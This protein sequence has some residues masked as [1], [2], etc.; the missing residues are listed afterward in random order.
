MARKKSAKRRAKPDTRP[1][2]LWTLAIVLAV[3]VL[4]LGVSAFDW[5]PVH[6]DEG[7]YWAYGQELAAGHF[8]KPPLVG[9]IIFLTTELGGT[10]TFA[11]RIAAVVAHLIVA[12]MVF[13]TGRLLW[14]GKTGFWAA[15]GYTAAPGVTVSSMI[16]TTDPVMMAAWAVALYAW[17]RAAEGARGWWLALG[18]AIGFGMLAKYTLVAFVGGALGYGLFSARGR[19]WPGVVVAVATALV[20]LTPNLLWQLAHD[21]ATVG[22]IA[23][24]ATPGGTLLNPGKMAEFV[25][26]QLGVIGPVWFVAILAALWWRDWRGD[27]RMRLLAW[28]TFPLLLTMIG[29]ALITRAQPNWAAPAYVAGSLMAARMVLDRKWQWALPVQAAAGVLAAALIYA[30]AWAFATH[31]LSLPRVADPFKKMRLSEPFCAPALA[32]M[33]E[34]GAEVLLSEDRRRLSECMFLGGLTFD[35]IAVWNPKRWPENHHELVASLEPGDDRLMVL[36]TLTRDG[37]HHIADRFQEAREIETAT[38]QTHADRHFGYSVWVVRGF[39]GY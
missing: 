2:G 25:G 3:A 8:S 11:L 23:E 12:L 18:A 35:D 30:A 14:D 5:V 1:W 16:M 28:Q 4:R 37:A 13:L 9:W 21:F 34:E 10:T 29:L 22:H 7:Q 38:V 39:K 33:A 15:A 20:I 32:A 19:D 27:W 24:D 26:A 17:V 36:A 6:F 31:P